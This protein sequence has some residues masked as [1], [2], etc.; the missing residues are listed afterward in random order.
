MN[1]T[2]M[3]S[4]SIFL[5]SREDPDKPTEPPQPHREDEDKEGTSGGGNRG[6]RDRGFGGADLPGDGGT[7]DR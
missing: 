2:M 5:R 7:H 4:G 6:D 1:K 3:Q